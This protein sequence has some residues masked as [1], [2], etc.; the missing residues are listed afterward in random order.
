[1]EKVG[2]TNFQNSAISKYF[3]FYF[4]SI[5][6]EVLLTVLHSR[7]CACLPNVIMYFCP[8]MQ[9]LKYF[10]IVLTGRACSQPFCYPLKLR[11]GKHASPL[12]RGNFGVAGSKCFYRL[13]TKQAGWSLK[14]QMLSNFQ[15]SLAQVVLSRD[16]VLE[17]TGQHVNVG[18]F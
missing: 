15:L 2:S 1:M 4:S 18:M 8:V 5:C 14:R 12:F 7:E 3:N 13:L 17:Q 11:G 16:P 10:P 9:D 6:A